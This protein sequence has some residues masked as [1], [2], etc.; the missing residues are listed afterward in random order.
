MENFR[1]DTDSI[2][3]TL[4]FNKTTTVV[5][6]GSWDQW[7]YQT[8]SQKESALY[9]VN[10]NTDIVLFIWPGQWK[11]DV[12]RFTQKDYEELLKKAY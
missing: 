5:I 2:G 10:W 3:K 1:T 8:K 9:K 12:F 7:F 11:T 4:F 6:T